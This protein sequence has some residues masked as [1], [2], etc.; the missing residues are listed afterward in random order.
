MVKFCL[1]LLV[2]TN[3]V[4]VAFLCKEVFKILIF[5]ELKKILIAKL[6]P[7]FLSIR[8]EAR[9][10]MKVRLKAQMF[11]LAKLRTSRNKIAKL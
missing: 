1:A 4:S 11:F 7:N 5:K 2:S 3:F 6:K 10:I 8:E 9:D